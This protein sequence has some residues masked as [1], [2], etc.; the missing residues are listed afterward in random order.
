VYGFFNYGYASTFYEIEPD[1]E[2]VA[3]PGR[4]H[5]PHDRRHQ[6]NLLVATVLFGFDV[7]LRWQFGSGL[8]FTRVRG[9]DGFI[10]MEGDIDVSEVRGFPRVI[11]EETPYQSVLP[12]YHRLDLSVERVF[13]LAG[14]VDMTAHLSILNVY[15]RANIFTL[16][17][18]TAQ[19]TDQLPIIPVVG[20][21]IA[22]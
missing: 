10:L 3:N 20:L 19:R 15:D 11:Y 4:Y 9:F 1:N 12:S 14:K 2:V 13:R 16:D 8:P 6:L 21:K 17:L 5:P 7:S 18:L 22:F